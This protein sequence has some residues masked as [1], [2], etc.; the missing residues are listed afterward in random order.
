MTKHWRL[1]GQHKE[2]AS[3]LCGVGEERVEG[4]GT[5]E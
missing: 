3:E 4:G 1:C 2:C 5:L